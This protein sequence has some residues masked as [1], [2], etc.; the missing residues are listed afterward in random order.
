MW[1]EG[2]LPDA[3]RPGDGGPVRDVRDEDRPVGRLTVFVGVPPSGGAGLAPPVRPVAPPWYIHRSRNT[4]PPESTVSH[5]G[6][7]YHVAA[8]RSRGKPLAAARWSERR[9]HTAAPRWGRGP[10]PGPTG[11]G[12]PS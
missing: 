12:R 4:I 11:A 9:G 3:A 1:A 8:P 2:A 10:C 6:V 5:S 7:R